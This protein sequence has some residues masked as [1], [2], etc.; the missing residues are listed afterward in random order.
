[1]PESWSP[2]SWTTKEVTQHPVYNDAEALARARAQLASFPPLVTSWE[3]ESLKKRLASAAR[4]ETFLLQGGDCAES[5]DACGA[6]DVTSKL[7]ILLQ[8][9]LILVHAGRKPVVRVGRIAGQYAKPRSSDTE[10]KGGVSLPS[11]RGDLVNLPAFDAVSREPN[12][13]LML[14]AYTRSAMTLNFMRA[15]SAGG[16][17][18]LH[19]PEYWD[20]SF[21]DHADEGLQR[22]YRQI[23][24]EIRRS[25]DFAESVSR[26]PLR[27]LDRVEFYT[28]HEGLVLHYEQA[29][30]RPVPRREGFYDLTTHMP[31]IG[32]RTA[33]LDGAHVEFFRGVR[34]PVG[35]KVG[36]G[37]DAEWLRGLVETLNPLDEPGRLVLIH[38]LGAGKVRDKLPEFID[39]VRKAGKTVVWVSDPMH[40]NTE[41]T[42]EG[43]KTRRFENILSELEDCF[44][45]HKEMG[46]VLG[47]VHFE[48]TGD[49]VTE[50]TGGSKGLS[51]RDL[52][53]AYKSRVDPRLNYDQAL[54]M[55]MSVANHMVPSPARRANGGPRGWTR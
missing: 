34:N 29:Q 50:C 21:V 53:R 7:K 51:D 49:D 45:V 52:K 2:D 5:F 43:I 12:P 40:G 47:G 24:S 10:T 23:A 13:E 15:L 3:V 44:A 6:D 38:R 9:S 35:V 30:T 46:S 54:E 20:L 8:M 33:A 39:T 25:I 27:E 18:D 42:A 19:H 14:R 55:A 4:G 1:M 48:L 11:Y 32:M 22:K 37:M 36:P 26:Q 41:S 31:W 16:F 28:S 17:A